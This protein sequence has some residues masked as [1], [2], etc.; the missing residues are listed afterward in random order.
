MSGFGFTPRKDR[1]GNVDP[2]KNKMFV[3]FVDPQSGELLAP[4]TFT[5]DLDD[6]EAAWL[7]PPLPADTKALL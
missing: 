2:A 4:A 5:T 7:T 6:A 3:R 1:Y